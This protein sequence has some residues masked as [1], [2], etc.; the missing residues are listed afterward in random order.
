M[1][2]VIRNNFD[3]EEETHMYTC[4]N[5]EACQWWN[6][7]TLSQFDSK[8]YL[9]L[10]KGSFM[11]YYVD[12]TL[13]LIV[14]TRGSVLFIMQTRV[15]TLR[16]IML[17]ICIRVEADVVKGRRARCEWKNRKPIPPAQIC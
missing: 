1:V 5:G 11:V 17:L 2:T 16:L 15:Q 4:P 7:I 12:K 13:R 14:H 8:L 3:Q 10:G 9:P 6:T